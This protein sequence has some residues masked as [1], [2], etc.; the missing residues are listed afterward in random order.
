MLGR[1]ATDGEIDL[2]EVHALRGCAVSFQ[3]DELQARQRGWRGR[4]CE[5]PLGKCAAFRIDAVFH[6]HLPV[7]RSGF[8]PCGVIT[9]DHRVSPKT[10]HILQLRPQFRVLGA[11]GRR[12]QHIPQHQQQEQKNFHRPRFNQFAPPLKM[13]ITAGAWIGQ[14]VAVKVF[15]EAFPGSRKA[16]AIFRMAFVNR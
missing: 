1:R 3:L 4:Q 7:C 13:Q 5:N 6:G 10:V 9:L 2:A 15:A 11:F 14:Y 16:F 8:G 12:V